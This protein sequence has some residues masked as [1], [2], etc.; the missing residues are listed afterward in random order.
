MESKKSFS[1]KKKTEW[2]TSEFNQEQVLV[3]KVSP[4]GLHEQ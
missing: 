2:G 1:E 4:L 3:E